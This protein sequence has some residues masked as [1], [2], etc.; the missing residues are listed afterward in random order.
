MSQN[1]A[2]GDPAT[3][4]YTGDL[5]SV[6][7]YME[8]VAASEADQTLFELSQLIGALAAD[9]NAD[10]SEQS[11]PEDRCQWASSVAFAWLMNR[12][13]QR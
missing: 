8:E 7:R 6:A 4:Q 5:A 11:T 1:R 9:L 2:F 10:P 12:G 3:R 13:V